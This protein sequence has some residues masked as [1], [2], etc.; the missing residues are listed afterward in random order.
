MAGKRGLDLECGDVLAS[1]A[2]DV[3]QPVDEVQAAVGPTPH[4]V[5]GVEPAVAPGVRR[6]LVVFQ[7]SGKE[8]AT[9]IRPGM[10]DEQLAVVFNLDLKV[11]PEENQCTAFRHAAARGWPR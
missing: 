5:A 9:R 4:R 2:D 6:R 3:L 10:A 7:V 8:A 11:F 1:A